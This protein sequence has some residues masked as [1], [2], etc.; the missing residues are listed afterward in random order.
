MGR[1]IYNVT[2]MRC[3]YLKI[4]KMQCQCILY[5][6]KTSNDGFAI[7][8]KPGTEIMIAFKIEKFS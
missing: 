6:K 3:K 8:P 4:K 2:G 7:A 5:S 1:F